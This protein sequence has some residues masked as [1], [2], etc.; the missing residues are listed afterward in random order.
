MTTTA[1][2]CEYTDLNGHYLIIN[3]DYV[4]YC[5]VSAVTD[6][7]VRT[8]HLSRDTARI[9]GTSLLAWSGAITCTL[10]PVEF[11]SETEVGAARHNVMVDVLDGEATITLGGVGFPLDDVDTVDLAQ[12]L[13]VW[14][15]VANV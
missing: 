1:T 10:E 15:G 2:F 12:R 5:R 13:I 14:A 8:A 4:D 7:A 11:P 9:L 6:A 3:T